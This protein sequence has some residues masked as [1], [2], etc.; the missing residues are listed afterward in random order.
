MQ[1]RISFFIIVCLVG[2]AS[3]GFA[4]EAVTPPQE[5]ISAGD[6]NEAAVPSFPY[7][8]E[9]TADSVYIRSGP[10]T[11]Y[12]T[13][14]KLNKADR[15]KVVSTQFGWS[16]I[17]PSPGCF[18]WISMPHVSIDPDN[19][20]VGIVTGDYVRVRAGS[21]DGNPLH[22]ETVQG[23]LNKGDKVKLL[24]EEKSDYYKIAPPAHTYLWVS[25]RYTKPLSAVGEVPPTVAPTAP[26]ADTGAVAPTTTSDEAEKL[27]EYY[28]LE[29]QIKTEQAKPMAQQDYTDIKKAL[30]EI[31]G[32][33]EAG[34]AARYSKFAAKKIE[35]FELALDVAEQVQLQD[36][37]FQQIQK[38]ID[39][40][41][42]A[43]LA[44]VQDLGRFTV[45][46]QFQTSS[47]YGPEPELK[48]YRLIDDS[49]RTICYTMP[50]GSAAG[51]DLTKLIGRR[52]GLLGTIEPHPQTAGA[53]VRF[54]EITELK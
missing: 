43:K 2:L 18:S 26:P 39:K 5:S 47:I 46:G 30:L 36:K 32:S 3:V 16:R 52:V 22:S 27:K 31:A 17:V 48:L 34:K 7:V 25:T 20:A 49:G 37:Q 41:R 51:M 14:G 24:G 4:Q 12:Y 28:A 9:I 6:A 50:T 13:C 40:A 33:K 1:S 8:A 19:P 35:R 44:E 42:D 21:E 23:M 29:K 53:L 54:T 11:N 38:R 15:V 45:V 10:G